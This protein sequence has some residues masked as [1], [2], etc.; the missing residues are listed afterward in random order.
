MTMPD[1]VKWALY[2]RESTEGQLEGVTFNSM[3]SQETFLRNWV[4]NG[5]QP[6]LVHAVYQDVESGT[7]MR[8]RDGLRQLLHDAAQ[9]K[10]QAAVAYEQDRWARNSLDY[11]TIKKQ[12]TD[13]G[14]RLVSANSPFDDSPEGDLMEGRCRTSISTSAAW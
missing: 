14:V 2:L 7:S 4:A 5:P 11:Q 8:G 1:V 3:E 6:G 13:A 10:F 12:L 9:G